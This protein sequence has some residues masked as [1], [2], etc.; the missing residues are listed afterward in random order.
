M[1]HPAS[2]HG[3]QVG[4]IHPHL[5]PHPWAS[6]HQSPFPPLCTQVTP[7]SRI[8]EK[9]SESQGQAVG[10][11]ASTDTNKCQD[12][13]R[14]EEVFIANQKPK[15]YLKNDI[16]RYYYSMVLITLFR[17]TVCLDTDFY[18]FKILSTLWVISLDKPYLHVLL[19]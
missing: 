12:R 6:Y 10:N 8:S 16:L 5:P 11:Q 19:L 15:K 1:Y 13:A 17:N 18:L 2:W 9:S 4:P 3:G 14:Q 7:Y